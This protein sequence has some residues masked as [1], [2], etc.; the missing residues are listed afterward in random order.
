[1]AGP[2][3]FGLTFLLAIVRAIDSASF[4]NVPS[5]GKVDTVFTPR[6]HPFVPAR[7]RERFRVAELILVA[8]SLRFVRSLFTLQKRSG[9]ATVAPPSRPSPW[10]G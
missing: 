2:M 1:M 6:T 3:P 4:V 7:G 9:T 8:R 10:E 5:G